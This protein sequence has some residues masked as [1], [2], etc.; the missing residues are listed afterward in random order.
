MS[1]P[2][3]SPFASPASCTF[4]TVLPFCPLFL[5][6]FVQE[7]VQEVLCCD[8]P[9]CVWCCA[10]TGS[11]LATPAPTATRLFVCAQAELQHRRAG[12]AQELRVMDND[13]LGEVLLPTACCRLPVAC[14]ICTIV[15]G[16]DE[17]G[18]GGGED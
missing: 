4:T 18:R 9:P 14:C 10:S 17:G 1:A 16:I 15:R 13:R 12:V 7:P 2:P 3:P 6:V 8:P 5:N 11:D